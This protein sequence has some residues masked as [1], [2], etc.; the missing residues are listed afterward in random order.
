MANVGEW[1]AAEVAALDCFRFQ[2]LRL[3]KA[4]RE[5]I[6]AEVVDIDRAEDLVAV[7][8]S[9][10]AE[11]KTCLRKTADM[12]RT[13]NTSES[14]LFRDAMRDVHHDLH[15]SVRRSEDAL[16]RCG[17]RLPMLDTCA[18]PRSRCPDDTSGKRRDAVP[19]AARFS[20][21]PDNNSQHCKFFWLGCC[22][23]RLGCKFKHVHKST[24]M[25]KELRTS[26]ED[27]KTQ[28]AR[29]RPTPQKRARPEETDDIV[30]VIRRT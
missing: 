4:A 28:I 7:H 8:D 5:A 19:S 11:V 12:H 23:N 21:M 16:T 17:V 26:W 10:R 15:A 13:I 20:G 29:G 27:F 18:V 14:R 2:L 9:V 30:D 25:P 6:K 24:D 3:T 22:N 1:R